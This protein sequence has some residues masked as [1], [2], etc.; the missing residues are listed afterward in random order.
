MKRMY[1]AVAIVNYTDTWNNKPTIWQRHMEQTFECDDAHEAA[2][3]FINLLRNNY[4]YREVTDKNID[5]YVVATGEKVAYDD[6]KVK[7]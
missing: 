6:F 3:I 1:K 5:I 7:K 4:G 2:N